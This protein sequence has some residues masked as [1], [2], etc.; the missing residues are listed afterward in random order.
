MTGDENS[1]GGA[2]R[3]S[4]KPNQNGGKHSVQLK[5]R[6]EN[7][8]VSCPT[9]FK[10]QRTSREHNTFPELTL[11]SMF[12][13]PHWNVHQM[14]SLVS[15]VIVSISLSVWVSGS[16]A[17]HIW[18]VVVLLWSAVSSERTF[19]IYNSINGD[20]RLTVSETTEHTI[21]SSVSSVTRRLICCEQVYI[22]LMRL[23]KLSY[24]HCMD[25][26]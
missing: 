12:P 19:R 2:W 24:T 13:S 23:Q 3:E 4:V 22:V 5:T 6:H 18:N 9:I 20:R 26:V 7:M 21:A 14:K 10:I 15:D 8:R 17:I 16:A 1:K 25:M 11:N